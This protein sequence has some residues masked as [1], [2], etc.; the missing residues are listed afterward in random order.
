MALPCDLGKDALGGEGT[1][2]CL[3]GLGCRTQVKLA[4]F[5]LRP[6]PVF[7]VEMAYEVRCLWSPARGEV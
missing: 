2:R 5:C 3:S 4:E 1:E 7:P 6:L